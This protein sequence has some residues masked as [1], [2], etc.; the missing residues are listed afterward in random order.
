MGAWMESMAELMKWGFSGLDF[1]FSDLR[2]LL[3]D[4]QSC[5]AVTLV[6]AF[7]LLCVWD[8]TR[9]HGGHGQTPGSD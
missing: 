9:S 1:S 5:W 4:A 8:D 3:P 2:V 7:C 6:T